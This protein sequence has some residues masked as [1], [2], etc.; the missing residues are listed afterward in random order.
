MPRPPPHVSL[1]EK[2]LHLDP[3]QWQRGVDMMIKAG[4]MGGAELAQFA[5]AYRE[6][7]AEY[8]AMFAGG[9]TLKGQQHAIA[10]FQKLVD[11]TGNA[12]VAADRMK[13]T[14]KDFPQDAKKLAQHLGI[15]P[16]MWDAKGKKRSS[17]TASTC[18]TR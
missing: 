13:E 11:M 3:S 4:H 14:L 17:R 2:S 8:A 6:V 10:M 9:D 18:Y 16:Y 15:N 7:G 12:E 1:M 5:G